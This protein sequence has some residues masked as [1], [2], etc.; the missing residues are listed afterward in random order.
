M[1]YADNMLNPG[2]VPDIE[3]PEW[4]PVL[5]VGLTF[6]TKY[7]W[8][9]QNMVDDPA[10]QPE[11]AISKY[12][13]TLSWWGNFGLT[14]SRDVWTEHDYTIDYTFNIGEARE[15]FN[16]NDGSAEFINPLGFSLG[17]I[18]YIFPESS[19]KNF[20]SEEFYAGASYDC[21]LQP[22]FTWFIDYA[23]GAG[24]YLE[25]GIAPS[26]ELTNG[27]TATAGITAAYNAG[28]WGYGYKFAP[29][30]FSGEMNIPVLKYFAVI[31]NINY[32][33]ALDRSSEDGD[34]AYASEFYGG[35]K[36]SVEF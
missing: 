21:L 20:H 15:F 23:R 33:L 6:E 11:A 36:V 31:P 32:S 34:P 28:Q 13:L 16:M 8:R 30:L 10:L 27:I 26:V 19:G 18:F 3:K 35:I 22:F 12:G 9:G 14:S 1:G 29:M 24:S 7:I 4:M 2:R 5:E 25:F 17:H